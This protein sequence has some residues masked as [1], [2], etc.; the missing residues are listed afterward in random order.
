MFSK[1]ML[2]EGFA[3]FIFQEIDEWFRI[4]MHIQN[5]PCINL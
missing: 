3:E 5:S 4:E 2:G 1:R